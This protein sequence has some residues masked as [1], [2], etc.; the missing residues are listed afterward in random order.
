MANVPKL[1]TRH[2]GAVAVITINRP[3][4]RNALDN[5]T[6]AALTQ[7]SLTGIPIAP[8]RC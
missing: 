7:A 1:L 3:E 8:S 2:D 4:V 6:A 5:E